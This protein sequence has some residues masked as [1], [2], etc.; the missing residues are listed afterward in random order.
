MLLLPPI[1]VFCRVCQCKGFVAYCA[2][3][4]LTSLPQPLSQR[5]RALRGLLLADNDVTLHSWSLSYLHWLRILDLRNNGITDLPDAAFQSLRNLRHLD[6]SWNLLT[7]LSGNAFLGLDSLWQ[8]NL[9]G[10]DLLFLERETLQFLPSLRHLILTNN[11]RLD[12]VQGTFD[13]VPTLQILNSDAY[14][15]CCVA[16]GV[17]ECTPEPDEFSSCEDLMANPALQIAIWVLGF[18]A[19]LGNIFVVSWRIKT[20]RKKVSS[21]FI[22]NLGVS[23]WLMGVYMLIIASVDVHYRGTY[24]IYADSWRASSLCQLAG[25]LAMLSSEVSV[26]MLT[27]ITM[28]RLVNILFPM[29]AKVYINMGK[30]AGTA[31]AG[32]LVCL[33]ITLLP[34]SK[35]NYFG[36]SFFG[37]TGIWTCALGNTLVI[38]LL[39]ITYDQLVIVYGNKN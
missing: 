27:V 24:I 3:R 7:L 33:V 13:D 6:L 2:G 9:D 23:D 30:A 38:L 15:F 11:P 12:M 26:F 29:K 36:E 31:M 35:M 22:I 16:K 28:D 39:R 34:V 1:D 17:P 21:F 37:R 8:L 14:R 19:F 4:N 25:V 32:W 20:D 5:T 10:N 18:F